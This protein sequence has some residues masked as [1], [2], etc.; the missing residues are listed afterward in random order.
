MIIIK[1]KK[2]CCGC[3]ACA[4]ACPVHC[5]LMKEDEEGFRYP[6]I[7]MNRCIHCGL[8]T[9]ICPILHPSIEVEVKQ[10]GYVV[11][12]KDAVELRDSTAGG[13][14]SVM[15]RQILRSGGVVFGVEMGA[16]QVVRHTYTENEQEIYRY[17]GSKYVQSEIGEGLFKKVKEFLQWDR[18]V[19]FSGTPCQIEGLVSYLGQE[20][21]K[22]ITV[23][24]VCHAVPSPLVFR[25]YLQYH[26]KRLGRTI[27]EVRFRDKYYGYKYSTV[28][29]LTSEGEEPYHRGRESDV[30][31][32]A[33]FSNICD[34]P[35]CYDCRF[36]KRYRV[37]DFTI[38]DCFPI[39][40]FSNE[41]NNDKGATRVLLHSKKARV[42]WKKL[43]EEFLFVSVDAD[44][45]VKDVKEM[46]KSVPEHYDRE[47]FMKDVNIMEPDALFQKYFPISMKIRIERIVRMICYRLGIY[48][49]VKRVMVYLLKKY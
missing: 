1:D 8:C 9:K 30:W 35:A 20:Y 24:V 25:K 3:T 19:L 21:E 32:R 5:I 11:Q 39:W 13:V 10:E 33:F 22:L 17:R 38:W 18:W 4:N 49:A 23:D 41:L 15:A 16:D 44:V 27:K 31:F 28:K 34:R 26:E 45:L 7:D 12:N 42:F 43:L 29:L 6:M 37:S 14:F 46:V 48:S 40:R 2:E 47:N 36:K